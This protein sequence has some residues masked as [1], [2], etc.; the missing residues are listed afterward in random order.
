MYEKLYEQVET[1]FKPF[2]DLMSINIETMDAVREKHVDLVNTLMERGLE[3]AKGM[4]TQQGLDDVFGM[5]QQYWESV[6]QTVSASAKDAFVL[7]NDSHEKM[8]EMLG[9]GYTWSDVPVS[10]P[11]PLK[12]AKEAVKNEPVKTVRK[13][14][15]AGKKAKPSAR[16]ISAAKQTDLVTD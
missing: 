7:L 4:S 12:P 16:N 10:D 14:T 9:V 8:G 6:Q 2:S 11:A 3:H 5:Q 1:L 15:A 13:K